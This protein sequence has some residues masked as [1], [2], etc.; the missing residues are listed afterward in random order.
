M[1]EPTVA[2]WPGKIAPGVVQ[3]ELATTMDLLATCANLAGAQLPQDRAIDGIKRPSGWDLRAGDEI[4]DKSVTLPNGNHPWAK[5]VSIE[6]GEACAWGLNQQTGKCDIPQAWRMAITL[7][8]GRV[9]QRY[10]NECF[11]RRQVD[12]FD[13]TPYLAMAGLKVPG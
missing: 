11:R 1:R 9:D 12:D 5:I 6:R 10:S 2:W 7:D 13:L 8:T 3:P 4:G